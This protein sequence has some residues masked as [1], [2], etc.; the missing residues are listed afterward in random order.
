MG[1]V[2]WCLI[3]YLIIGF[4]LAC[5]AAINHRETCGSPMEPDIFVD[6]TTAWGLAV[7]FAI[8]A[9]AIYGEDPNYC[10]R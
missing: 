6:I 1:K 9:A 2:A 5:A 7:P 8:A 3:K 10:H 4:I